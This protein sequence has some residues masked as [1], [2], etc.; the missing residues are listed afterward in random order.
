M[1]STRV[2]SN[3]FGFVMIAAGAVYVLVAFKVE[4]S[5]GRLSL[6]GPFWSDLALAGLFV[7][8]GFIMM[9]RDKRVKQLMNLVAMASFAVLIA[10][11]VFGMGA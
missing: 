7:A 6:G 4:P 3:L 8:S 11:G 1:N 5:L 10:W 2:L 9:A